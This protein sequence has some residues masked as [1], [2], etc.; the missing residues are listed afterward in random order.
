VASVDPKVGICRQED[1]IG[2]HFG[3]AHEMRIREARREIRVLL[4]EIQDRLD[5][6]AESD[7]L[8]P[9]APSLPLA[10]SWQ[11]VLLSC[12]QIRRQPIHGADEIENAVERRGSTPSRPGISLQAFTHDVGPGDSPLARF[13]VDLRDQRLG[14]ADGEGFHVASV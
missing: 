14:Q 6:V 8:W 4:H 9:K 5:M 3:H 10:S 13:R 12:A 2:D 1:R 7:E 11:V